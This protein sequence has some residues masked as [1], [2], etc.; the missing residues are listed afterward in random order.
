MQK[1]LIKH[2]NDKIWQH[3]LKHDQLIGMMLVLCCY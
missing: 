3:I 2:S 1:S